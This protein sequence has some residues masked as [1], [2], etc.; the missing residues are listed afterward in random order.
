MT[1]NLFYD[2]I[3]E[4][5]S[6]IT[7]DG[8][9]L[10]DIQNSVNGTTIQIDLCRPLSFNEISFIYNKMQS[11]TRT[12]FVKVFNFKMKHYNYFLEYHF[13]DESYDLYK[14]NDDKKDFIKSFYHIEQLT[15]YVTTTLKIHFSE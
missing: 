9:H 8:Y 6:T 5:H 10:A 1:N 4:Y 7:L 2:R 13:F 12:D 11:V 14:M 3:N 15:N